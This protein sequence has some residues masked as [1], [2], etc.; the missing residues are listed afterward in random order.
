MQQTP[1]V[2]NGCVQQE[3]NSLQCIPIGSLEWYSWLETIPSFIFKHDVGRFTARCDVR[4]NGRYW[5]AY[6]RCGGKLRKAY[7]GK[8][9]NLTLENLHQA[10]YKLHLSTQAV[11]ILHTSSSPE[12]THSID[13]TK[14][15]PHLV[16]HTKLHIPAP[17][18]H[19]VQRPQLV[20]ALTEAIQ[21]QQHV[22]ITAPTGFGKTTLVSLWVKSLEASAIP[23]EVAWLTLDQCDNE[24]K[25]FLSY[26]VTAIQYIRHDI[27]SIAME[28]LLQSGYI[29]TAEIPLTLLINDLLSSAPLVL[30]ID[31][32]HIINQQ[33]IHDA[34]LFLLNHSPPSFRIV[35]TSR[36]MPPLSLAR[37][38][39]RHLL[40]E[41]HTDH[42]RLSTDEASQLLENLTGI[43]ITPTAINTLWSHTEGWT[44][45][46]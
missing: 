29:D 5:Y 46:L 31:D 4:A 3:H 8:T 43:G 17:Q 36:T 44:A 42:I 24:L 21:Q 39:A 14:A 37:L 26:L 7:L 13:A 28:Y 45:A 12:T 16:L 9:E 23:V 1:L 20:D 22:L 38:R 10:A 41:F 15:F 25:H 33:A 40:A 6:R 11:P 27:G 34:L 35:L 2:S 18:S 32:Y 19:V 30:V